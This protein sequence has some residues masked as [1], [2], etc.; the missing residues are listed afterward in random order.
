M[1]PAAKSQNMRKIKIIAALA[2]IGLTSCKKD[3]ICDCTMEGVAISHEEI[4]NSAKSDAKTICDM[5]QT[6]VQGQTWNCKLY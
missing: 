1:K 6:S 5:K 2:L 4:Y 3:Y